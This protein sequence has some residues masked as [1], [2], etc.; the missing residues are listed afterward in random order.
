MNDPH[1]TGSTGARNGTGWGPRWAMLALLSM[2][3]LACAPGAGSSQA[4]I[5]PSASGDL[6]QAAAGSPGASSPSPAAGATVAPPHEPPT[7]T[8]P[9][10]TA[11]APPDIH[12]GSFAITVV[13]ALRVRSHPAVG[14]FSTRYAP[15]L[16]RDEPLF[17]IGGPTAGSGYW[18][19]AVQLL[20]RTLSGGVVR[21]WVAAG[22]HDGTPWIE[23]A[24]V[25]GPDLPPAFT[26]AELALLTGVRGDIG[27][28][29]PLRTGLPDGAGEAIE[30]RPAGQVAR[31]VRVTGFAAQADALAEYLERVTASGID[32]RT[33]HGRC[34]GAGTEGAYVPGDR[35]TTLDPNRSACFIDASGH[36]HY[37]ATKLPAGLI[38]VVG[39][40]A[41]AAAVE[42]WA[43]RGGVDTPG[44]PT[45]WR[46]W[47]AD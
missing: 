33:H 25:D 46:D 16:T 11:P 14:S 42:A 24:D 18:W 34:D 19:Y 28:C 29:V 2:T 6:P 13:D 4:A 3:L 5:A 17:V 8:L 39:R 7:P 27:G 37:L 40:G 36:A 12:P 26:P 9:P 22:D 30:C 47:S 23:H 45:A 31:L 43:W 32:L 44:A 1:P 10:S 21:G 20:G 15:L 38:E 35:G 41:D